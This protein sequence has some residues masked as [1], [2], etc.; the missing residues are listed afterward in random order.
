MGAAATIAEWR[1]AREARTDVPFLPP[2]FAL[3][4]ADEAAPASAVSFG[5]PDGDWLSAEVVR[6][7]FGD[8]FDLEISSVAVHGPARDAFDRAVAEGE[9][10]PGALIGSGL[11]RA[12]ARAAETAARARGYAAVVYLGVA[13]RGLWPVLRR[14]GYRQFE[15]TGFR[16]L[17]RTGACR[18]GRPAAASF[19]AAALAR[20]GAGQSRS[21]P[22][23]RAPATRSGGLMPGSRATV[24]A[25]SR[26]SL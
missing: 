21:E 2:P 9:A 1:I 12:F 7:E 18:G 22:G 25:A 20:F 8:T 26:P 13:E 6:R 17:L 10:P 23:E 19:Y 5:D 16:T 14:Y 15:P 4:M 11:F 3:F 24:S